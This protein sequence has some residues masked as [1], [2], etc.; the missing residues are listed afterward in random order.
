M[1]GLG[2]GFGEFRI[3]GSRFY[4]WVGVLGLGK[5]RVLGFRAV[6]GSGFSEL[7]VVSVSHVPASGMSGGGEGSG[8]LRRSV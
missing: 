8:Q 1:R 4:F 2:V 3:L 5:F 7:V 6:Q